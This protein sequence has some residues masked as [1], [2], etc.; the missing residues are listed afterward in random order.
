MKK[1]TLILSLIIT[2]FSPLM[3]QNLTTD[4]KEICTLFTGEFDNFQ[5]V[6]QEI[7][8]KTPDSLMHERIHSIFLPVKMPALGDNVFFVK[9][10]MDGDTN[11]IYRMRVYNLSI[12]KTENAIRLDI[13]SFKEKA[14]ETR[15]KSANH[16]PSVLTDLKPENFTTMAGCGVFWKRE[17]GIFIGSMK[18]KA[19]NFISKRSNKKVFITDSLKL[20]AN[21]IWIRDEAEDENGN[22]IFGHKGKIHHKLVRCRPF[23]GWISWRTEEGKDGKEDK[24]VFIGNLKLHDQGWKQRVVLPDGT[25]TPFTVELSQVIFEK[26]ISVLKLA[27]YEEGKPKAMMYNWTNPEAERIG[28][29]L[30]WIQVGLTLVK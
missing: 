29:N 11:N 20:T 19:C 6:W 17:N 26:R 21:E 30:R 10:Y 9:Q 12:D 3:A 4:L 24:S 5:Q 7:E 13:Y 2:I 28:I 18:S 23:K 27:I 14:D 15:F 16:T 8:D 22:Y 1:A 25:V